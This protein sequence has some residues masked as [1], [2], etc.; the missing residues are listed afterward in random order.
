MNARV[1]VVRQEN[2]LV[3]PPGAEGPVVRRRSSALR[4]FGRTARAA[5]ELVLAAADAVADRVLEVIGTRR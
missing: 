1:P 3:A 4:Q 2:R 5:A